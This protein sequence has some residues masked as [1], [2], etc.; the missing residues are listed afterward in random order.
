M[1]M[2]FQAEVRNSEKN[3]GQLYG[4]SCIG[5]RLQVASFT[6]LARMARWLAVLPRCLAASQ[7]VHTHYD[8]TYNT[9][10]RDSNLPG[11]D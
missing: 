4:E 8:G 6:C 5:N 3:K 2:T 11:Q 7:I 9:D 1:G 10:F